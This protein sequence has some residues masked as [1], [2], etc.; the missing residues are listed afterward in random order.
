MPSNPQGSGQFRW[1]WYYIDN[2]TAACPTAASS[3]AGPSGWTTS[4]TDTRFFGTSTTGTGIFFDAT[5]TPTTGRTW[6]LRIIPEANG[7]IPACGVPAYT[8][9]NR[10]T[11]LTSCREAV[12]DLENITQVLSLGQNIPNPFSD[13]T[14][15]PYFIPAGSGSGQ[16]EIVSINGKVLITELVH[17]GVRGEV[18]ILKGRLAPGTYFYRLKTM[19]TMTRTQKMVVQ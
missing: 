14:T 11:R 5:S 15:I 8:N 6:V 1:N 2:T 19:G 17:E 16:L 18:T 10:T 4:T 12:D 13:G 9:C 7:A 3:T